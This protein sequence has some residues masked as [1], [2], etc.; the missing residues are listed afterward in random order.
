MN[1]SNSIQ[2]PVSSTPNR[3]HVK[4]FTNAQLTSRINRVRDAIGISKF[5][6]YYL[7]GLSSEIADPDY[8]VEQI[9]SSWS[10]MSESRSNI[11]QGILEPQRT[12]YLKNVRLTRSYNDDQLKQLGFKNDKDNGWYISKSRYYKLVADKKLL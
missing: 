10:T 12:V 6:K 11:M 7:D 9:I 3:T 8:S 1:N 4:A 5:R 2:Q